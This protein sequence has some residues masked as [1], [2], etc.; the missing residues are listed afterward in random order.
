[1]NSRALWGMEDSLWRVWSGVSEETAT[2]RCDTTLTGWHSFMKLF[3]MYRL[4][5]GHWK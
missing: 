2:A 5:S 1:M 4:D 3:I